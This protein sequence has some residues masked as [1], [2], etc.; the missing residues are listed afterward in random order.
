MARGVAHDFNNVLMGILGFVDFVGEAVEDDPEATEDV[1]G[2]RKA[3]ERGADLTR[4]LLAFGHQT[5][6]ERREIDAATFI[7]NHVRMLKRLLRRGVSLDASF[8][9]D[10]WPIEFDPAQLAQIILNLVLN[11]QDA[12]PEGGRVR[13]KAQNV[14]ADDA[15]C[16]FLP[17]NDPGQF[18]CITVTDTGNGI[19]S[20]KISKVF[21]PFYG[22]IGTNPGS[23]LARVW[24]YVTQ[25][26]GTIS[27]YSEV[28]FGTTYKIY[29]PA[30]AEI[31]HSAITRV[32]ASSTLSI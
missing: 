15:F 11:A 28:E 6:M 8:P 5:N 18:L 4:Q 24:E 12:M 23:G 3:I 30:I 27:V 14:T 26:G 25:G 2:I 22:S 17:G 13:L 7:Y 9:E 21:E 19:P 20:N 29:L 31:E 1:S 32:N 10:L 16:Q